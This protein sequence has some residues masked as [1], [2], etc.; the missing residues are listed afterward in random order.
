[1]PRAAADASNMAPWIGQNT[2]RTKFYAAPTRIGRVLEDQICLPA[3]N[4]AIQAVIIARTRDSAIIG[5]SLSGRNIAFS[6]RIF[7]PGHNRYK[8]NA[9]R[10]YLTIGVV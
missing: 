3:R 4:T 6:T 5:D 10:K 8:T 2:R 9:A 1:M 7:L